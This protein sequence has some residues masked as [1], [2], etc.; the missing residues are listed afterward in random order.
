MTSQS[1]FTEEIKLDLKKQIL[2]C[3]PDQFDVN[4]QNLVYVYQD[5]VKLFLKTNGLIFNREHLGRFFTVDF[6]KGENGEWK[7]YDWSY[8]C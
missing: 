6:K 3:F 8:D 1:E 2:R 7:A 4:L 5:Q